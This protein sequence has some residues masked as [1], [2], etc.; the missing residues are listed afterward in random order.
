MSL[1]VSY[2]PQV[3]ILYLTEEGIAPETVEVYPCVNL[4]I[5]PTG[6]LIGI[7]VSRAAEKLLGS[8]IVEPMLNGGEFYKVTL[9]GSLADLD[10]QLRPADG[11]E[12]LDYL[13]A[14]PDL[15]ENDPEAVK[16]LETIRSGIAALLGQVKKGTAIG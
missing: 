9:K 2:D 10:A 16:T 13:E 6:T 4:E 8:A 5:N 11:T 1:Q 15:L 3:D 14:W 7:E 12:H